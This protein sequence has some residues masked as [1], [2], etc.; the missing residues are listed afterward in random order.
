M[1]F[2]QALQE[3]QS[4]FRNMKPPKW[5]YC[6]KITPEQAEQFLNPLT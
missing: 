4:Q 5:E 1:K 2:I 6:E 3:H